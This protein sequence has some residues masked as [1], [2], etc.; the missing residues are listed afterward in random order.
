M[1]RTSPIRATPPPAQFDSS[2]RSIVAAR[3]L[4]I[5][6][7]D[8]ITGE[9]KRFAT[10]WDALDWLERAGFSVNPQPRTMRLD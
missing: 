8:F 1:K 2:T 10:H 4:D 5:F 7:Y 3:R 9:R 6:A